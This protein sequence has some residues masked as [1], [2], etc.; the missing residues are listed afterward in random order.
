MRVA[1]VAAVLALVACSNKK[2][3]QRKGDAAAVEV[4]TTP[5]V[6]NGGALGAASEEIEPNDGDGVATVL[7]L[8]ATVHGKIDPEADVDHYRIDVTRA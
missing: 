1:L 5:A 6:P 7:L 8:G 3:Q 2:K 4:V